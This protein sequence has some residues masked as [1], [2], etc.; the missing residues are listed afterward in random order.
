MKNLQIV[1]LMMGQRRGATT[2][3]LPREG[4]E[5]RAGREIRVD[6]ISSS[7]QGAETEAAAA[8]VGG[9]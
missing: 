9:G 4:G 3:L 5:R 7:D 2:G 8:A 1:V 6:S